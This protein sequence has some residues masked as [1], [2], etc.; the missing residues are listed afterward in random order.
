MSGKVTRLAL[1]GPEPRRQFFNV[2]RETSVYVQSE[3]LALAAY[4]VT[5]AIGGDR[6]PLAVRADGLQ[7]GRRLIVKGERVGRRRAL[8]HEAT[9]VAVQPHPPAARCSPI[10]PPLPAALERD[11]VVVHANVA[12]ATHGETV[13][14]IL[15]AGDA[16][17]SFQRFELKRLPLTYRS[18]ANETGADS[19]LSVRVG[20]VEWAE[21]PTLFGA[22]PTE[23]AYTLS[24][25]EQGKTLV[26]FGDGVRG[27]RLP[28]GREQRARDAIARGSGATATSAPTSS[29]S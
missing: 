29:R 10:T 11:T 5:T 17:K 14:Q 7:P 24:T 4:P 28:S 26:V 15:G 16:S 22:A 23:R 12:L 27:A 20:D 21:R 25:D 9:L 2:P 1:R 3:R 18:A 13:L 6:L 8:V 19:E